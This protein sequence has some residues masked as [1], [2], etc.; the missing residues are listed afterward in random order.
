MA[1]Y[2]RRGD[3]GTT[4]LFGGKSGTRKDSP[5]IA[6]L[7]T[8]DELNSQLGFVVSLV[9]RRAHRKTRSIIL[10]IQQDLFEIAAEVG[11]PPAVKPPFTLTQASVKELEKI[12]D[13]LEGSL[14]ALGN[15]IF[16]GG[17]TPGA[18]LHVAR[19]VCR[20]LER[21]VVHLARR[22]K[23]NPEILRYLNRLSDCLFMLAREVNRVEKK[24]EEIWKGK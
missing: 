11:T 10:G 20:R 14:P 19:S 17:S 12:I 9:T 22:E 6:V 21:E 5:R 15:F 18:S 24:P 2:T 1:I 3:R 23:V 8:I 4:S 7:G 16:P 13:R